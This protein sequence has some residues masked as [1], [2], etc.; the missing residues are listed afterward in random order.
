MGVADIVILVV[1]AICA[2]IGF[3]R[4]LE[5]GAPFVLAII[6]SKLLS[7]FTTNILSMFINTDGATMSII[8]FIVTYIIL[9]LLL[10]KI[11]V[12]FQD[13]GFIDIVGGIV[14]GVWKGLYVVNIIIFIMT[15]L[16]IS[17]VDYNAGKNLAV[18]KFAENFIDLNIGYSRTNNYNYEINDNFVY[19][20][21]MSNS[22]SA[23]SM[24]PVNM[25]EIKGISSKFG[26]R[27]D[28][29]TRE[30]KFHGGVDFSGPM[31]AG[32][33]STADGKVISVKYSNSGYGNNVIID[34]GN[35]F[36]TRYAHMSFIFVKI[37][38]NVQKGHKIG[39]L[40][41]SGKSTGPHLHYEVI[42]DNKRINPI[43]FF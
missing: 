8:S 43:N 42:K 15:S 27:I 28:P 39:T 38:D 9:S 23:P 13:L 29:I 14:F 31:G 5:F 37:G 19:T 34:H 22:S 20:S 3:S 25:S 10:K 30:T 4:G 18:Y 16:G 12:I 36:R 24:M 11:V 21:N 32:I 17:V 2:I 41:N 6:G 40:G 35:G 1:L 26:Q 7:S 33:Y